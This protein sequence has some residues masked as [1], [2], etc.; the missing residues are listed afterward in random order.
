MFSSSIKPGLTESFL[1]HDPGRIRGRKVC[2]CSLRMPGCTFAA[3]GYSNYNSPEEEHLVTSTRIVSLVA[4]L[5]VSSAVG[6]EAQNRDL[7]WAVSQAPANALVVVG[8]RNIEGLWNNLKELSCQGNKMPNLLA[9]VE[10]ALPAGVDVKGSIVAVL[11]A[12]EDRP[13]VVLLSR[14]K[15]G[16]TLTGEEVEGGIVK[17]AVAAGPRTYA[18]KLDP[19]VVMSDKLASVKAFAAATTHLKVT[20]QQKSDLNSRSI[21]AW[22]NTKALAAKARAAIPKAPPAGETPASQPNPV[23]LGEWAVGLLS[24]LSSLTATADVKPEAASLTVGMEYAPNSQLALLAAAAL[25]LTVDK[26]PLPASDSFLVAGWGRMDWTRAVGP[27][28]SLFKPLLDT[29]I[30]A[31]NAEARKNIADMWAVYDEWAAAL[32]NDLG[33]VMEPAG[34]GQGMYQMAETITVKDPATYR[35]LLAKTIPLSANLTKSLA[36]LGPMQGP[37]MEMK[38]DFTTGAET[39]DGVPVDIS[40]TKMVFSSPD[41]GQDEKDEAQKMMDSL[42]GP[43][44]MTMRMALLGKTAIVSMGGKG[45]MSRAIKASKGQ[46]PTLAANAKV[47]AALARAP[48]NASFVGIVSLPTYAH[49]VFSS[50]MRMMMGGG[51][52]PNAQPAPAL[53]D[54]VTFSLR[55]QGTT[56]YF[57][58]H[59]PQSEIKGLMGSIEKMTGGAIGRRGARPMPSGEAAPAAPVSE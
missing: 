50:M 26:S 8:S 7:A 57:D 3:Q 16:A 40:K 54:L 30:P 45:T 12:S 17:I 48:K 42:Y 52:A 59:L 23:A 51:A 35:K 41:M 31:S 29:I 5:I 43:E 20:D 13:D 58:V 38:T 56:Q 25:P 37:A 46:A 11:M 21:W 28:K 9:E 19:W 47:E 10:K 49:F 4:I 6:L 44:G 55:T 32:G 18:L 36:S 1:Q 27:G 14:L 2:T 24:Q 15:P 33:F 22:V 53:G 34:D 39:I